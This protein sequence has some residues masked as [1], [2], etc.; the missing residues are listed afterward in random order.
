VD[1]ISDISDIPEK[2]NSYDV[3][4]CTEV[5]EHIPDPVKALK[6]FSRL[7]KPSGIL[8]LTTPVCSLTH[9]SP[10]YFYN[11]F[12]R[13]YFEYYFSEFG[14]KIKF[15]DYN[16]NF[17]EYFAQEFRRIK[18]VARKYS[19]LGVLGW[20]ILTLISIPLMLILNRLSKNDK[21]SHEILSNG[22]HIMAMKI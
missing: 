5:F 3:I 14:F 4:L 11:G 12:S 2:D 16:G 22:I 6:E 19:K 21:D 8:I 20:T 10:N 7:L 15:L 18:T 9:K 13:N 17:F 1:I